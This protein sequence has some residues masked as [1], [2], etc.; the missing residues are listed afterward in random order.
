MKKKYAFIFPVLI[1]IELLSVINLVNAF[2]YNL[3]TL[4][5]N[6]TK[7]YINEDI[8]INASWE[9]NYNINNEIAYIQ[10]HILDIF[11]QIIWNSSKYNQIGTFVKNWTVDIENFNLNFKNSSYILYIKFFVF[12]FQI[13]TTNTMCTYLDSIEIRIMKRNISCELTGYKDYLKLGENLPI[14]AK[15][16]DETSEIN[17]TLN[18]Q[19][20]QFMISFSDLIIHQHNY[21]TNMSGAISIHLSSLT[22]LNLGQNFLIFSITN[23]KL[24]NDSKFIYEIFTE[25][26]DLIIDIIAFNNILEESEDLEI[27][28]Y[29]YYDINQSAKPLV[30]YNFLIKIFVNN[31]LTFMNENKTNEFGFLTI[32]IPQNSFNSNP[33][34]QEFIISI[35]FNGTFFLDN[36]TLTLSLKIK[37]I[38]TETMNSF[39]MKFF[40]F[41]SVLFVVLILLSYVIINKKSK[42]GKLLTELIIRY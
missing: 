33:A 35:I 37:N 30:D 34:S 42:N 27:K 29:C 36:K 31:T 11:D 12:Y 22:H 6:Q 15:F 1:L 21:T 3:I 23:N 41:V 13:D 2:N 28:L 16:Y 32:I 14:I 24:Y 38:Y 8:K 9:L 20:I 10:I 39:Q 4:D 26:N 7:Y 25:K 40:S 19:T 18:N 5:T 17:Q